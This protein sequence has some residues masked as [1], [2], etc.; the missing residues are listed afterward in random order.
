MPKIIIE[1]PGFGMAEP[2][3]PAV[4]RHSEGHWQ[5][6]FPPSP[7]EGRQDEPEGPEHS[8]SRGFHR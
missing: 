7:V 2:V 6:F 4:P 3:V 5:V 1:Q 8:I